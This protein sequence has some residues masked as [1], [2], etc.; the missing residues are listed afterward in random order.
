M[1]QGNRLAVPFTA[2]RVVLVFTVILGLAYPLGMVLLAQVPG[3][4]GP[5]NG[6]MIAGPNGQPVGSALIGQSFTDAFGG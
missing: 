1:R 6:S 3:L 4:R 5:A 2:L